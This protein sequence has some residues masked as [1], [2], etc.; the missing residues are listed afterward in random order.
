MARQPWHRMNRGRWCSRRLRRWNPMERALRNVALVLVALSIVFW[1]LAALVGW[2]LC[3]RALLPVTRMAKA[4]GSMSMAHG[5]QR[6]P[7]PGTG[8][9]L[10][11]LAGSFNGLLDRL[12]QEFETAKAIYRRCFAPAAHA[13]GGAAG[14]ARGRA[15]PRAI[16]RGVSASAGRG[17]WRSSPA[18]SDCRIAAVH[19]PGGER[20]RHAG[21]GTDRAGAVGARASGVRRQARRQTDLKETV[22][23]RSSGMG[24]GAAAASGPVAGAIFWT[25]PASTVLR[26]RR[27][28]SRLGGRE[29]T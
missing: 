6:L 22:D 5:D 1:L 28:R 23:D 21:A 20:G 2:R 3:K 14:P 13:A 25:T 12:H 15:A 18:A 29:S 10:D 24:A 9:E 11:L 17:S 27:S 8:D 7:M 19:G 4:A 26:G 16:G